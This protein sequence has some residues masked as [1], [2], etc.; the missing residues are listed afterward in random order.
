MATFIPSY[1]SLAWH[2]KVH[3]LMA[4]LECSKPQVLGHLHMLWWWA[5]EY[6]DDGCLN[7]FS[8]LD[9][10]AAAGWEGDPNRFAQALLASGFVDKDENGVRLHDW[11]EYGGKYVAAKIANRD[12]MR[13]VR[14]GL[15][16]NGTTTDPTPLRPRQTPFA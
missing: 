7:R 10:A 15:E 14:R 8:N 5:M 16:P 12:R 13:K 4:F 1:A 9:L 2:P 6:A 11:E 3:R